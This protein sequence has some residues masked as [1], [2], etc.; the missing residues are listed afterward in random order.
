MRQ[1]GSC[2][3]VLILALIDV[4]KMLHDL[5]LYIIFRPCQTSVAMT[6]CCIK[7][8]WHLWR[9]GY[10]IVCL[11][12]RRL[13]S[14]KATRHLLGQEKKKIERNIGSRILVYTSH[15]C[16]HRTVGHRI[17]AQKND[18]NAI[19]AW[20]TSLKSLMPKLFPTNRVY[21][22]SYGSLGG[23]IRVRLVR[24]HSYEG[25]RIYPRTEQVDLRSC[26]QT[27]CKVFRFKLTQNIEISYEPAPG[28]HPFRL[29]NHLS[30]SHRMHHWTFRI[31]VHRFVAPSAW[32][33][34][35]LS[36][37]QL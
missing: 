8:N 22:Y 27:V 9:P 19:T 23:E 25:Q 10:N 16:C 37:R 13:T 17:P 20:Y 6:I 24:L 18:R 14:L 32:L 34:T 3:P 5:L 11:E 15:R 31:F 29:S 36:A 4:C 35:N 26:V 12:E 21:H 1:P 33:L 7:Y 30:P 2:S 28:T